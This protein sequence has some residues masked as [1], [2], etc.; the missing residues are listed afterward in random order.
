M[1]RLLVWVCVV[2][3]VN[4]ECVQEEGLSEKCRGFKG[5]LREPSI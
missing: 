5:T 1:S 3:K 2:C 4:F